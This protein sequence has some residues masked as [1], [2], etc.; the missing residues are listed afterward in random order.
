MSHIVMELTLWLSA[1]ILQPDCLLQD[2]ALPQTSCV[3]LG[4]VSI[5]AFLLCKVGTLIPTLQRY[6]EDYVS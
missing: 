4:K 1:Q 5:L 3:T 6:Y 2:P